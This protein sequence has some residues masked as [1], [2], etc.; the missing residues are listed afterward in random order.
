MGKM[1]LS[2]QLLTLLR[3]G[4]VYLYS[5][6]QVQDRGEGRQENPALR[7]ILDSNRIFEA[8]EQVAAL[9]ISII[10]LFMFRQSSP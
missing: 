5:G 2:D 7:A 10:Y 6:P 9:V 8:V 3:C 1:K 4:L